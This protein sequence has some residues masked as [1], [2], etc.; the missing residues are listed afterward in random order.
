MHAVQTIHVPT[1]IPI[2][3]GVSVNHQLCALTSK[4]ETCQ[5]VVGTGN[6]VI[7]RFSDIGKAVAMFSV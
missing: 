1:A 6:V 3:L 5:N 7:A 4:P 2:E